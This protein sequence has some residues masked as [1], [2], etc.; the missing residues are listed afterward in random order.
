MLGVECTGAGAPERRLR[1]GV[2][3]SSCSAAVLELEGVGGC[4]SLCC[5]VAVLSERSCC[6]LPVFVCVRVHPEERARE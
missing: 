4:Y 2:A 5:G 3:W 6:V 1:H